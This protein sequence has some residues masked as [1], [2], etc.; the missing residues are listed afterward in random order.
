MASSYLAIL[1]IYVFHLNLNARYSVNLVLTESERGINSLEQ[2]ALRKDV[3]PVA[4]KG[5]SKEEYFNVS[6]IEKIQIEIF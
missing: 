5:S 6:Q 4:P 1:M 2:L 3:I